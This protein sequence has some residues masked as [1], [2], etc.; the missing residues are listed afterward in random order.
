MFKA[1]KGEWVRKVFLNP[2]QTYRFRFEVDKG[3]KA[4]ITP[5]ESLEVR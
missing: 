5:W 3:G 2:A 4:R 1:G